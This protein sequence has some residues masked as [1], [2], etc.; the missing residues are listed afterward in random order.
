MKV[1]RWSGNLFIAAAR[2]L[3]KKKKKSAHKYVV[4]A[5]VK[6]VNAYKLRPNARHLS[7]SATNIEVL[8]KKYENICVP[9]L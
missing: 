9:Y 8:A 3:R 6:R 5:A 7:M 2:K 4:E 1:L